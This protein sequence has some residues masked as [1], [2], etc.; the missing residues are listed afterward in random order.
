MSILKRRQVSPNLFIL[1]EEA[2]PALVTM[3]LAIGAKRAALVDSGCGVTGTLD[4]FVRKLTDKP[5]L[6]LVTHCDP[7]HAG[8]SALFNTAYMNP[9]DDG[10]M[11]RALSFDKRKSDIL[12]SIPKPLLKKLVGV[13]LNSRMLRAESFP[14]ENLFGGEVFDLG[15]VT[16]EAFAL[17]GHTK[18][19]T[20][21]VNRAERY[22]IAGDSITIRGNAVVGDPRCAPLSVYRDGL[23]RFRAEGF[24]DYAVYTGHEWDALAPGTVDAVI[25]A[26]D[27]ILS[28]GAYDD[29]P[30][31]PLFSLSDAPEPSYYHKRGAVGV[32]YSGPA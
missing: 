7:D 13:Y 31:S 2:G 23:A 17:P 9:A 22:V 32:Y 5:V 30:A 20:C 29:K 27:E 24:A 8:A 15:G 25:A 28:G 6:H 12:K 19:S 18:G 4:R 10:L 1:A 3:A 14:H 26:C 21:Y 11:A 16:L